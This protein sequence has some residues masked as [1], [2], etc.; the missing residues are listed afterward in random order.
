MSA[1]Q[2]TPTPSHTHRTTPRDRQRKFTG[3]LK[4]V[5]LATITETGAFVSCSCGWA[6]GPH[7]R[8]KLRGDR[9]QAHLDK[10][11]NGV[12]IWT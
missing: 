3:R 7:P 6:F 1:P 12:G 11:H 4:R 2:P 10:K 8:Q 5:S 9:A